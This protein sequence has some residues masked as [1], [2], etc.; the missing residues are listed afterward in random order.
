MLSTYK[1]PRYEYVRPPEQSGADKKRYPVVVVGAGPVGLAAA[2]E[3]AQSG[4]PVV[5]LDDDDTVSVGSRGV[6]YAKRA[7]EVLDRLGVGDVS[8]AKGVSW[9]VGAHFS[10]SRRFTTSTCCRRPTTN[11]RA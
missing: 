11:A 1:Y 8:V 6:C 9:N 5:V 7:L 10:A 4:V 3:L 2:I